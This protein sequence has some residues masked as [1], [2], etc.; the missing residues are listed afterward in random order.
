MIPGVT[1]FRV[2]WSEAVS[3]R[4]IPSTCG[5]LLL[6]IS[7]V[8]VGCGSHPTQP[9]KVPATGPAP[10]A[11]NSVVWVHGGNSVAFNHTP[12]K[13]VS[14]DT[15][16]G[17]IR[18]TFDDSLR[19]WWTVPAA[20]GVPQRQLAVELHEAA[21]TPAT[22]VM[23]AVL[24]G[25]A[26]QF[27]ARI[28]MAGALPNTS[29][30]TVITGLGGSPRWAPGGDSLAFRYY[31]S[32]PTIHVGSAAG[33]STREVLRNIVEADWHPSARKLLGSELVVDGGVASGQ[34]FELNLDTGDKV[35]RLK[36]ASRIFRNPRY[37]PDGSS[38]AYATYPYSGA[39]SME[40]WSGPVAGL[41]GSRLT[42]LPVND[43]FCWSPD[44]TS[45]AFIR[46]NSNQFN[47]SNNSVWVV[48][49][50]GGAPRLLAGEP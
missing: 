40:L 5:T 37:S 32:V 48:D 28:P 31:V 33:G 4:R 49:V 15:H 25:G 10:Q 29:A 2:K 3:F 43:D 34:I 8:L 50:A 20:G 46:Y 1:E 27:L 39:L 13:S 16:T 22:D 11:Y 18:Y 21:L 19:G 30:A 44:G 38:I 17:V 42:T 35:V 14:Y 9:G 24:E 41:P 45:I 23:A 47:L 12:L 7:L 26:G 36:T 6:S